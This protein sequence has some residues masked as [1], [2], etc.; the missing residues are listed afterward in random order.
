MAPYEIKPAEAFELDV[1][2]EVIRQS[3]AT[4]AQ[5]FGLTPENCPS[6]GAF[7]KTERLTA[8]QE[9]GKRM[10]ALHSAGSIAGF[11][12]VGCLEDG[13]FT[14][15]KLAVLP[16][17]RHNGYGKSLLDYAIQQAKNLGGE[18]ISIGIIEEHTV[19]K[20][21]YIMSGFVPTGS[22]V[23]EHLPFT[24]GFMEYQISE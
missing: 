14:I 6:N 13:V 20:N 22:K 7:L 21:W 19:L 24:V 1:C 17:H 15:E 18:K 11:V 4:V 3:F 16:E 9:Q 2:A 12:A 10:F 23:F 8:E 5:D